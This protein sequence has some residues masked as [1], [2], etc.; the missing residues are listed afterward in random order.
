MCVMSLKPNLILMVRNARNSIKTIKPLCLG[1]GLIL[2]AL[3]GVLQGCPN[4][5]SCFYEF[6][7]IWTSNK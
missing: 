6:F 1:L 2:L 3:V 5:V 7:R 4:S